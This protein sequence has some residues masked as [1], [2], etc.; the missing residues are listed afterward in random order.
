MLRRRHD[1]PCHPGAD[2]KQG[3]G[4][5]AMARM[6]LEV[7]LRSQGAS[8]RTIG[9]ELRDMD[10]RKVTGLFRRALMGASKPYVRAVK[11]SAMAIPTTGEK[12]TGLR[13][14]IAD[15]AETATWGQGRQV[16]VAVE[17]Q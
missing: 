7:G 13:A 2:R 15:C 6:R 14:R 12:H 17:I 10:D 1:E 3:A 4:D 8:L 5:L 16:N 9:R 11:V